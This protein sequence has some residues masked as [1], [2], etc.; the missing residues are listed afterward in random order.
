M[1]YVF[2]IGNTLILFAH[3]TDYE[4]LFN[5][6][7]ECGGTTKEL[8]YLNGFTAILEI[9]VM[10]LYRRISKKLHATKALQIAFVMFSIKTLLVALAKS[11]PLLFFGHS[12]QLLSY[13]LYTPAI[14]DYVTKEVPYEDSA[15][16]QSL[17]FNASILAAVLSS[18]IS[19]RLFDNVSVSRTMFISF[20][21]CVV[22]GIV[23]V[24][25]LKKSEKSTLKCVQ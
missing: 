5:I 9:P 17:T 22:G 14:V 2:L 11:I 4:F 25:S 20:W 18:A 19:G 24:I 12:F 3:K 16:A 15:K 21:I 7:K 6:V 10:F 1:V 23:S 8:G 13:G